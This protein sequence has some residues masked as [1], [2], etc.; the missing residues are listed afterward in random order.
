VS[1]KLNDSSSSNNGNGS[2]EHGPNGKHVDGKPPNGK[3]LING[4]LHCA[5]FASKTEAALTGQHPNGK[6]PDASQSQYTVLI[7]M[8]L[9]ATREALNLER[10]AL[11]VRDYPIRDNH[12]HQY[13]GEEILPGASALKTDFPLL[14]LRK[15]LRSKGF[16]CAISNHAGTF[17]CNDLYYQSLNF[18]Q[19]Y[20]TPDLV[21]FIHVP[22]AHVFA[23]AVREKGSKRL[24]EFMAGRPSRAR[25]LELLNKAIVEVMKFSVNYLE[26]KRQ[27]LES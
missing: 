12:G 19:T 13:D 10:F 11:N 14:D 20:G 16:P 9:A 7:L 27:S 4:A 24:E 6:L 22:R 21:L 15:K 1:D 23:R 8:G 17:V 5:P 18:K 26:K 3:H 2:A 25:Q